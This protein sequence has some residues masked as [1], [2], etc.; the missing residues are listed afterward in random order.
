MKEIL[1]RFFTSHILTSLSSDILPLGS[2][3][4][5]CIR[6]I[7][8]LC[9]G[10]ILHLDPGRFG[11]VRSGSLVPSVRFG[12][13]RHFSSATLNSASQIVSVHFGFPRLSS[14]Q[15]G[16]PQLSLAR[17]NSVLLGYSVSSVKFGSP[18]VSSVQFDFPRLC[19]DQFGSLQLSS[20]QLNSVLLGPWFP[21]FASTLRSSVKIGSIRLP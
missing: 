19:S 8:S 1:I 6:L 3:R 17:F 20:A 21:R 16:S 9:Q 12:S 13:T 18:R 14:V 5:G 4:F 2:V 15:F 10:V 11:S 7:G